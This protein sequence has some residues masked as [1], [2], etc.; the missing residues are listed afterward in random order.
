MGKAQ[1]CMFTS[2][3]LCSYSSLQFHCT[4]T[5][6]ANDDAYYHD[7]SNVIVGGGTTETSLSAATHFLIQRP[8]ALVK[9]RQES[10]GLK[11]GQ[12][13]S[14]KDVLECIYLSCAYQFFFEDYGS[15][16]KDFTPT[17]LSPNIHGHV[18]IFYE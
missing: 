12:K 10:D 5:L 6:A 17:H 1:P 7:L 16:A 9:L 8:R 3:I 18:S 4:T 15:L 11:N 14:V 2:A 13:M